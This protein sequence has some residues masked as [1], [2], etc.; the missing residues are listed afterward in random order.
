MDGETEGVGRE[1]LR[2]DYLPCVI[3]RLAAAGDGLC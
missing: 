1:C 2:D 3:V